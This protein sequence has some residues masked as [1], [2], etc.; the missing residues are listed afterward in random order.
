LYSGPTEAVST[1]PAPRSIERRAHQRSRA[2]QLRLTFLGADHAP[3]NWS[4]GGALIEDRHPE[5]EV[6]AVIKG[7]LIFGPNSLR[8]RFAAEVVRRDAAAKKIAI[9]FIDPS[10]SLRH[11]LSAASR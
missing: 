5:L 10:P 1:H 6:G 8:Y 2:E 9:H 11:A 4:E 3:L 7:V